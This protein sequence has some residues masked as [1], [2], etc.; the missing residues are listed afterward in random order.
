[1]VFVEGKEQQSIQQQKKFQ[2]RGLVV[3]QAQ[4]SSMGFALKRLQVVQG[5]KLLNIL[6]IGVVCVQWQEKGD[7]RLQT[8]FL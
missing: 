8:G 5:F 7:R 6:G 4:N 3:D 2:G 1:M